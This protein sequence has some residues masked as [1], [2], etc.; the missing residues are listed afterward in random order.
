L[1][2]TGLYRHAKSNLNLAVYRAYDPDL[3]RWLNRDPIAEKG[4]LNLYRYVNNDPI[5]LSDR[6]GLDPYL[7]DRSMK[8][9][10]WNSSWPTGT[11]SRGDYTK[12]PDGTKWYPHPED[13]RHWPHYDTDKNTR[14]PEKCIKPRPNQN[15]P[16]YGDQSPTNPWPNSP[17]PSWWQRIRDFPFFRIPVLIPHP[18]LWMNPDRGP[19][20][21]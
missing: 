6:L 2:F 7:P 12:G 18:D 21:A 15:R 20:E 3:G 1:N 5:K 14:Y 16:P 19:R 4:G 9:P 11:D 8:P 17:A 10:G 13:Q